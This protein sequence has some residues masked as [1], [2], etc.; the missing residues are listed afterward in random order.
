MTTK[1]AVYLRQSSDRDGT[2]LGIERQRA[3]VHQLVESRGYT[4]VHTFIDNDVSATSKKPRP[5]FEKM[6]AGV[7]A[8]DFDAIVVRHM[9]R[10]VRR[11][12]DLERV[13]A[14]C[15]THGVHVV[16]AADGVDTS[17]DGGRLIARI[18]G[19]VA[20]GEVERKSARQRAAT[21]QAAEQGKRVGG[22]RPF[23]YEPDGLTIREREA[24][25]IRAGVNDVLA[26][27][28]QQSIANTWNA[29][30]ATTTNGNK[31]TRSSVSDVLGNPR[32]AGL[33]RHRPTGS[34][35]RLRTRPLE[36][37]VGKAEWPEIV[38]ED[39]WRAMVKVL[40]PDHRKGRQTGS[41]GVLTGYGLCAVCGATIHMGAA[42]HGNRTYRCS[43]NRHFSRKAAPIDNWCETVAV[44]RLG[45]PDAARLFSKP[46]IDVTALSVDADVLRRR[47]DGLAEDYADGV[48]TR[49]QMRQVNDRIREKL[50][51]VEAEL[52]AAI[53]G[54][55]IAEVV[56]A[57]DVI[58]VWNG[59]S[60]A[61]K[62][63][64]MGVLFTPVV[65]PVGAGVRG[66]DKG[67]VSFR[68]HVPE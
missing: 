4:I 56:L 12:A 59:L 49:D 17:T 29:A 18:L 20:Q 31:W 40:Y 19:S 32:I 24:A 44:A 68:W 7:A 26:G 65:H 67:S 1:I 57:D 60:V 13:L 22:R 42:S 46:D 35:S 34:A 55:G 28:S 27:E 54:E 14:D 51:G 48:L 2:E 58:T 16:S 9:D 36:G 10:L 43:T 61:R 62:R 64:V 45:R 3:D 11:L 39:V 63:S 23:G 21:R 5:E 25:L 15:E 8:G 38:S 37:I 52:A 30:G 6:M 33:R 66:F 41:K 47:L 53:S 50:A